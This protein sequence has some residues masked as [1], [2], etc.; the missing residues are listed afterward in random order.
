MKKK[1]A[2]KYLNREDL[3]RLMPLHQK[4]NKIV[5]I[6][7]QP[8]RGMGH[9]KPPLTYIFSVSLLT[10]LLIDRLYSISM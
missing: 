9:L 5:I 7:T 2:I 6:A 10:D 8:E 4:K 1:F 3:K